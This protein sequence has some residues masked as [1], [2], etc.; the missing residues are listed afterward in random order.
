MVIKENESSFLK[1]TIQISAI[2]TNTISTYKFMLTKDTDTLYS[3]ALA[4]LT[5]LPS[6]DTY[7]TEFN[8]IYTQEIDC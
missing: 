8:I 5:P 7:V 6:F 4:P 3:G 1:L 2:M